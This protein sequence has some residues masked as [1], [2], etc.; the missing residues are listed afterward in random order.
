MTDEDHPDPPLDLPDAPPTRRRK[1]VVIDDRIGQNLREHESRRVASYDAGPT[2][3]G[4][5]L[6]PF[7]L[8]R[9]NLF[10][11]LRELD[12]PVLLWKVEYAK[13]GLFVNSAIKLLWLMHQ[14]EEAVRALRSVMRDESR[15]PLILDAINEWAEG[16]VS[17]R[18]DS[19]ACAFAIQVLTEVA[20]HS[21]VPEPVPSS[22]RSGN[23]PGPSSPRSSRRSSRGPAQ[24]CSAKT[25]SSTGSRS[26]KSK[27]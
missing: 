25:T 21:A 8:A 22:R 5:P 10:W 14:P 3:L 15:I 24:A 26:R 2:W 1:T 11:R 17:P 18:H 13:E 23:E 20:E 4:K 12:G 16:N 9:R 27:S 19:A 7:S 6:E